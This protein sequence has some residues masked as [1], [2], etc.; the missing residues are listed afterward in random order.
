MEEKDRRRATN[1]R[2]KKNPTVVYLM[3]ALL[4]FIVA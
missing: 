2:T 4:L 3:G 1:R